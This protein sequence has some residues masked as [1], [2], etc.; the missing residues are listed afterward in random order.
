MI[1]Y[2]FLLFL[3]VAC[4]EKKKHQSNLKELRVEVLNVALKHFIGE[5]VVERGKYSQFAPKPLES[6]E[7]ERMKQR[8]RKDSIKKT[9]DTGNFYMVV[10]K[11]SIPLGNHVLWKHLIEHNNGFLK[12]IK[13]NPEFKI[14]I[15]NLVIKNRGTTNHEI[16]KLF[17]LDRFRF[18]DELDSK[19]NDLR[20]IGGFAFSRIEFNDKKTCAVVYMYYDPIW[21]RHTGLSS[22]GYLLY[23]KKLHNKWS[24]YLKEEL[25]V[26]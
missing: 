9:L 22:T 11:K 10:Q 23:F 18:C 24:L 8:A 7:T 20:C 2:I 6:N 25:W 15:T 19:P 14:P 1:K 12:Q 21:A 16:D 5:N 26:A 3:L 4:A 17:H 13:N